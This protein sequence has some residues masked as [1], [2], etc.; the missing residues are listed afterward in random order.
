MDSRA[1]AAVALVAAVS[2]PTTP[3]RADGFEVR[4]IT[5]ETRD[6]LGLLVVTNPGERRIYLQTQVFDWTQDAAGAERLTESDAALASP[7]AVWVPPRSSYTM[8]VRLPQDPAGRERAFRIVIKQLPERGDIVGG[9]VVFALTQSLPAFVVPAEPSPPALT[10]RLVDARRI[11]VSN[12]GGRR[13]RLAD[14][15]QDGRVVASG[16]VGYALPAGSLSVSLSQPVHAGTLEVET[17]Q[18]RRTVALR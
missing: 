2:A 16:L 4:P 8:R 15:R 14:I 13:A 10:A 18:G 9:R 11:V 12:G 1:L 7:P 17:D 3:A 6:G 5:V